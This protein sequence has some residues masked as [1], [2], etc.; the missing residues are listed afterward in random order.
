MKVSEKIN[1]SVKSLV[2]MCVEEIKSLMQQHNV[3]DIPYKDDIIDRIAIIVGTPYL[4]CKDGVLKDFSSYAFDMFLHLS[5]LR[6]VED[7]FDNVPNKN[8]G[9]TY[10][11]T[12]KYEGIEYEKKEDENEVVL[13]CKLP[14]GKTELT[15]KMNKVNALW[16]CNGEDFMTFSLL[17]NKYKWDF[18]K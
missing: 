2:P 3:Q 13:V 10:E 1:K 4:V 12:L 18:Y 6:I 15:F 17:F 9:Y 7:Y 8:I 11:T 14:N 16:Y 5:W